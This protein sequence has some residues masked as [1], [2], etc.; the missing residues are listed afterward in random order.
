MSSTLR[1]CFVLY[2]DTAGFPSPY[3]TVPLQ[4]LKTWMSILVA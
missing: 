2:K 3:G 1:V 4:E